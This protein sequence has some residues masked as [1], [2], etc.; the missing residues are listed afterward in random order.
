M[1]TVGGKQTHSRLANAGVP[2]GGMGAI[3]GHWDLRILFKDLTTG[4]LMCVLSFHGIS[5]YGRGRMKGPYGVG[6][7]KPSSRQ[8]CDYW[9]WGPSSFLP[10]PWVCRPLLSGAHRATDWLL[11][12]QA[13][14]H[15]CCPREQQAKGKLPPR[16][17]DL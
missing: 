15:C 12:L 5:G 6:T 16:P 10:Q 14:G 1:K 17:V 8:M 7:S 13:S 9:R 11:K 2:L 3:H 4:L